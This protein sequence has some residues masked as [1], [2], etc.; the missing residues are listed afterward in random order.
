M[1]QSPATRL[2][3]VGPRGVRLAGTGVYLPRRA[4]T[5]DELAKTVDTNDEWISKRTGIRQ[6]RIADEDETIRLM[7]RESIRMAL[8]NAGLAG[9][10]LD[11]VIVATLTPE[12]VTPSTAACVTTDLGAAPAGAVDI[13]AACSG[14]VYALNMAWA[15]IKSGVCNTVAVA[16]TEK[17][18]AITNWKDRNTCVLFGDGGGA[19]ILTASDDPEQGSIYQTMHSDAAKSG[20]LYVPRCERDLPPGDQI[21]TGEYNTLQ[22]NG[23][24]IYKFAVHTLQDSIDKALAACGLKPSDLAMIIPHQM[25]ARILESAREKLGL[26]SEKLY[27]NIDRYGNTSAASVAICLHELM[28]AGRLHQGDLVLFIG[29]GGGLTWATNLWRV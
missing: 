25:N 21:F 24:E 29:L 28:A 18:S 2:S 23:R 22:M 5:N 1:N 17:L 7:A 16:G 12:M 13:S 20:E 11:F 4:V 26:S 10:D 8:D 3:S 14:Y 15:L 19:A 9:S 6:R 27:V